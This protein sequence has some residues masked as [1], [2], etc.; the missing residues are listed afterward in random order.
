M[1]TLRI[2]LGAFALPLAV[3]SLGLADPACAAQTHAAPAPHK[4][5]SAQTATNAAPAE[6]EIPQSIFIIPATTQ[7]GKDPF[8]PLS[9]RMQKSV[10]V[11]V[12][13]T[14]QP[15]ATIELELKGVSGIAGHRLAIINNRSF[16]AG[17]EGEVMTSA[18]RIR[19][20]C[21]EIGTNSV[22]VVV[23]GA[24]RTL[25]LRPGF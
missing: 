10:V 6:P 12:I 5:N 4:A 9:K 22:Q 19:I 8:F 17:E 24:E 1:Q 7:Q 20:T 13:A 21:R 15:V 2:S 3:A 18:G 23:N 25:R 14:T 16:A 11:P